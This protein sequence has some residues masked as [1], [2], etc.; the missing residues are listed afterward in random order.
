[1]RDVTASADSED[2]QSNRAQR[3]ACVMSHLM[4]TGAEKALR[5]SEQSGGAVS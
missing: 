5:S 4:M 2:L 1:M 3:G